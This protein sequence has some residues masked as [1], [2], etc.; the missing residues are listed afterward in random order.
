MKQTDPA[1]TLAKVLQ[2]LASTM[3][4]TINVAL[5]CKVLAFG[6]GR[7]RIQPLVRTGEA[8]PAI[9]DG[10][11]ALGQRL[12]IGGVPTWCSPELQAGD[13]V[14]AVFCDR[15]IRDALGG[16]VAAPDSTRT[17]AIQDAVIVG[18]IGG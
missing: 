6:G 4:A 12:N 18:V 1:G 7:A 2:Q 16:Q 15:P 10:V 13:V 14:L 9:I 11:P 3:A 17:H 5:P 8:T